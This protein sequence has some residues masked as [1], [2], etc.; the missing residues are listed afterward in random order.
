MLR[1][2]LAPSAVVGA[3]TVAVLVIV[4]GSGALAGGSLGLLV[5]LGFY[6][7]G[8]FLLSRLVTSASPQAFFAVAMAVYLGQII[9][10]L[11]FIMAFR[12]ATW[13]DRPALGIVAGVVTIAWQIFAFRALRA[14]RL[15]IYDEP[16]APSGEGA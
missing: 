4:R 12:D 11:L 1:G 2:A 6:A 8:M 9:A 3:L 16:A 14:A 13:V 5:A 15:P 7:S 10:L